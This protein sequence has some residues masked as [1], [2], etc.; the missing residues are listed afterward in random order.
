MIE[1]KIFKKP[2]FL[3]L[4]FSLSISLLFNYQY[5]KMHQEKETQFSF[6]LNDFDYEIDRAI[7]SLDTLIEEEPTDDR[8]NSALI[9][10]NHHLDILEHMLSRTPYYIGGIG[11]GVTT[12][13][14][15]T[16]SIINFG[17]NHRG[18]YIP[19]FRKDNE[20]SQNELAFLK[21]FKA[22]MDNIYDR[23]RSEETGQL[24]IK[25]SPK[26]NKY[27]FNDIVSKTILGG[28]HYNSF[29]D[30]YIDYGSEE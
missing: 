25:P 2:L 17:T 3:F 12:D 5:Y 24:V 1:T 26:I 14:G 28:F 9:G 15:R 23:L 21:A 29:L 27:E 8:L 20:L 7:S 16:S 10:L 13:I 22:Y 18:H 6:F 4:I 19:P 30:E 11:G